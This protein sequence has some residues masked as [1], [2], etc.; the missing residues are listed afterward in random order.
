MEITFQWEKRMLNYHL[1]NYIFNYNYRYF[2]IKKKYSSPRNVVLIQAV[3]VGSRQRFPKKVTLEAR[4]EEWWVINMTGQEENKGHSRKKEYVSGPWDAKDKAAFKELREA[5][6]CHG[7]KSEPE[8]YM[9]HLMRQ[10]GASP[11]RNLQ[12]ILRLFFLYPKKKR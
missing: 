8:S 1:H 12:V 11:S 9:I 2:T 10:A 6:C 5:Q 3:W 4:C 7:R